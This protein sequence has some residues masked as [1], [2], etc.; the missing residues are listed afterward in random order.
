MTLRSAATWFGL[1]L[2]VAALALQFSITI[3]A[4]MSK[5]DD[6][7][8]ALAYFFSYF[9]I[10]TNLMLALIY[11]S[12][13]TSWRWLSWW[14]WPSTQAMMVGAI[15]LVMVFYHFILSGSWDPQG[16]Q[17]VADVALHYVT[18]VVY[19]LWWLGFARHGELAWRHLLVMVV[20][21]AIYVIYTMIRGPVIGAY[22]YEIFNPGALNAAGTA[23]GYGQVAISTAVLLVGLLVL[24][25]AAI[26]VDRM[27]SGFGNTAAA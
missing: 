10:L 15:L 19:A 20:P 3:P 9:T 6:L 23:V 25:S 2:G 7:F 1:L 26:V 8:G 4:Q 22:P 27:L 13:V 14:R 18:P 17:K 21:P 11:L 12:E 16:W 5:G 24:W